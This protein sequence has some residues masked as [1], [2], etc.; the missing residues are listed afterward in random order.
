M[1]YLIILF[2][3]L[4]ALPFYAQNMNNTDTEEYKSR[5]KVSPIQFG[6]SYFEI[7]Y[8]RFINDGK[9]SLQF[10]PMVM[11]KKNSYEEFSGIQFETQYRIYLKKLRKDVQQTWIFT[12]ID[13]YSGVYANA[14][15]Y[16][17]EEVWNSYFD[18][19]TNME[20]TR[21][22]NSDIFAAEGGLFVGLELVA[23][24]RIVIDFTLG[25]RVRYSDVDDEII[26]EDPNYQYYNYYDV[27]DLG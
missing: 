6:Q 7:S 20:V 14:M 10:S 15:T 17:E 25:G 27:F 13:L 26:P 22:R 3:S 9:H 24:K 12:N 8:E 21:T 2:L 1:R 5:L 11:L 19:V 18:P 16:N 4:L 23:S